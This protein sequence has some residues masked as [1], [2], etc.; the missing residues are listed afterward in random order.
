MNEWVNEWVKIFV[1]VC[2]WFI[3]IF[4]GG[5]QGKGKGQV[6][7]LLVDLWP[8]SCILDDSYDVIFLWVQLLFWLGH[9]SFFCQMGKLNFAGSIMWTVTPSSKWLSQNPNPSQ[10]IS[11]FYCSVAKLCLTFWNPVNC[12]MPGF[13]VVHCH[14]EFAETQ[15]VLSVCLC[16]CCLV[17]KLCLTSLWPHG[18]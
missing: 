6:W 3:P 18:L 5:S 12:S 14:S 1:L 16:C 11:C 17:A 13:P 10:K 15:K 9:I 8:L 7:Y 2:V 4:K